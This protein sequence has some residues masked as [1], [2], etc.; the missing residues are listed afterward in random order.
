V[1]VPADADARVALTVGTYLLDVQVD[2]TTSLHGIPAVVRVRAPRG[3]EL[4]A[5]FAPLATTLE[6]VD[7]GRALRVVTR[8]A[9]GRQLRYGGLPLKGVFALPNGDTV[10]TQV[11][12]NGDGSYE[13]E[14]NGL[15]ADFASVMH[16]G[17]GQVLTSERR[18]APAPQDPSVGCR[19]CGAC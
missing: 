3:D 15:D 1:L 12:D 17:T 4:T 10:E 7:G 8:D 18:Q 16:D 5:A 13:L 19:I 9:F 2:S 11:K 14:L 6:L